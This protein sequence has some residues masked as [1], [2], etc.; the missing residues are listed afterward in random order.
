MNPTDVK[1]KS[2]SDVDENDF[3]LNHNQTQHITT[4]IS[5]QELI[6]YVAAEATKKVVDNLDN[7]KK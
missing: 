1:T 2:V 7:L 4:K 5:I 3:V 6:D